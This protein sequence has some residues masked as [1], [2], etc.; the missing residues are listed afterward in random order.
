MSYQSV[1]SIEP[2]PMIERILLLK[3]EAYV[4]KIPA[5]QVPADESTG[6]LAKG[7]NL[8]KPEICKLKL[9]SKGTN[10]SI[11]LGDKYIVNVDTYPG[12]MVQTVSDSS[13]YFVI[14]PTDG[15]HLGLGFSDRS[16]SFDLNM[17]LNDHFKSLRLDEEIAKE[18]EEPREQ[19]DLVRFAIGVDSIHSQLFFRLSKKVK[20]L[21]LIST[22]R[23]RVIVREVDL[24]RQIKT[25]TQFYHHQA[26]Q[27]CQSLLRYLQHCTH[28]I[29]LQWPR[30]V[31]SLLQ[32]LHKEHLILSQHPKRPE[33]T[34]LPPAQLIQTGSNSNMQEHPSQLCEIAFPEK[35]N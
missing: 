21:K 23:G 7:W 17:A 26:R 11:K 25:L 6:W 12:P 24:Q 30:L 33:S 1:G 18:E 2:D 28:F 29:A 8:E 13:R 15:P 19:L 31:F 16:D 9:V 5:A 4:Y 32:P 20:L 34:L 3:Q 14:K 22:F 27:V 35:K 10:C